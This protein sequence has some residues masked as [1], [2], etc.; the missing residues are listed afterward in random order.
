MTNQPSDQMKKEMMEF[1]MRTSA[2]RIIA[3]Q[4]K[5][6]ME[7]EISKKEEVAK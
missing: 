3:K 6:R 1:F 4:K 5:E 2:P 7:R